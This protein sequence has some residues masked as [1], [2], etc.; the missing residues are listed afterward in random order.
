MPQIRGRR[1]GWITMLLAA[2]VMPSVAA[3]QQ[4]AAATS[5]LQ[6]LPQRGDV[7]VTVKFVLNVS[8]AGAGADREVESET[9]CLMIDPE[10]LVL[11]SNTELGGYVSLMSQMMGR[12]S[13]FDVT[14][15]PR[16]LEVVLSEGDDGLDA[17]LLARDTERDLAWVRIEGDLEGRT[18]AAVD[19][20]DS[21]ELA[22]GDQFYRLRRMDKFFGSQP[23]VSEGTVAAVL[24]KPRKLLVPSQPMSGGFGLPVFDATGK[25][26]GL[27]VIQTP[28]AEDQINGALAGGM[29]FLSSAA[30]LQDM[31]GGLIL[32]AADL[33]K[34]T[35]LARESFAED[36][37]DE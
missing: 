2:L 37:E 7:L 14:A 28:G 33:A 31:V 22:V 3:A 16:G 13:G 34:A 10:G 12:G 4:D 29:S 19:L 23:V 5:P 21:A 20:S 36:D 24:S 17:Q 9:T 30:K 32:P 27:T 1:I 35:R 6:S 18:I 25:L 15:T 11:C 26:V 8:M